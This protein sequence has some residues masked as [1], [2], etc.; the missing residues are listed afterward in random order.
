MSYEALL[1]LKQPRRK[2]GNTEDTLFETLLNLAE[3]NVAEDKLVMKLEAKETRIAPKKRKVKAVIKDSEEKHK[4]EVKKPRQT[5]E[6]K[7][8]EG[9]RLTEEQQ[10][11]VDSKMPLIPGKLIKVV[12]IAGS[13]KTSSLKAFIAARKKVQFLYLVFNKNM[14]S[15]AMKKFKSFTNV[16]V[17]TYHGLAYSITIQEHGYK[18]FMPMKGSPLRFYNQAIQ[19]FMKDS[20]LYDHFAT[21]YKLHE[22]FAW[23]EKEHMWEHRALWN[24]TMWTIDKFCSSGK[25]EKQTEMEHKIC[26]SL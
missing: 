4:V 17:K 5:K 10:A 1:S 8:T 25:K 13:G 26:F 7:R 14:C 24:H 3:K 9:H 15:E 21:R 18:L 12:A 23:D 11:F 19:K 2:R 20:G 16:N 6:E 22:K